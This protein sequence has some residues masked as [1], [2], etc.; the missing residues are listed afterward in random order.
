MKEEKRVVDLQVQ[1]KALEILVYENQLE[2]TSNHLGNEVGYASAFEAKPNDRKELQDALKQLENLEEKLRQRGVTEERIREIEDYW[3]V[4]SEF[5]ED[6]RRDPPF[7]KFMETIPDY[8]DPE[9]VKIRDCFRR[10]WAEDHPSKNTCDQPSGPQ[11]AGPY[12]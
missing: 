12:F 5:L 11:P 8:Y 7:S 10:H 6:A 4:T 3:G 1:V 9:N 2:K